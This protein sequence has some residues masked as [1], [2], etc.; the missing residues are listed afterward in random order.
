M[1][2]HYFLL[3]A[4]LLGGCSVLG[5]SSEG[6]RNQSLVESP[7]PP[8]AFS[9]L[10]WLY[11]S[12][13]GA[14]A[15]IQSYS[16]FREYVLQ[17]AQSR[18]KHSVVLAE[19]ASL[20]NP[21]FAPCGRNAPLAVVLDIDE[22]TLQNLGYQYDRDVRGVG[23][24]ESS[25]D[26]WEEAGAHVEPMPGA[27]QAIRAIKRANV[28]V[29]FNSNRT[30]ANSTHT[31]RALR[32]AGFEDVEYGR[33]LWLMREGA[34]SGKDSRRAEIAARYCVVALV[35]DQ[36]GDFSDL[37]K[38]PTA[39]RREAAESESIA[40]LWGNGW[41]ILSNPIYGSGLT[42]TRDDIFPPAVRWSAPEP[43]RNGGGKNPH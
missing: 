1:A 26:H 29:V 5:T 22:T 23:W 11:G 10:Q 12:G 34:G 15:S 39:A 30:A 2:Q 25:W 42:G 35:G 32:Y 16:V 20:A 40:A 13:E 38:V 36:L 41:F 31:E 19:G 24:S 6:R 17:R 27:L 14:A 33:N 43:S 3:V 21:T 28:A 18:P 8:A 37:F 4:L 9:A 7:A